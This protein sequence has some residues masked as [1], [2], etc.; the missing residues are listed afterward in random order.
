MVFND[1]GEPLLDELLHTVNDMGLG[2]D[3]KHLF[4]DSLHRSTDPFRGVCR[5][6]FRESGDPCCM[7][8][9]HDE[10]SPLLGVDLDFERSRFESKG[11]T[12][13]R[14]KGEEGV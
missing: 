13:F 14:E 5:D 6:R 1:L 7:G 2:V 9:H 4:A 3:L 10:V 12:C 8:A 11:I